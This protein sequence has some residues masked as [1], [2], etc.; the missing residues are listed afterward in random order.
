MGVTGYDPM[1]VEETH[2]VELAEINMVEITED[3]DMEAK[4]GDVKRGEDHMKSIYPNLRKVWSNSFISERLKIFGG[5]VIP[6]MQCSI[7][8]KGF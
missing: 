2:C 5:D 1:Q 8:Q 6:K 7:R 4:C 3:F